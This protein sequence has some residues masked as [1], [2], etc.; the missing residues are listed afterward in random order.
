MGYDKSV[1]CTFVYRLPGPSL[2]VH[3]LGTAQTCLC[4]YVHKPPGCVIASSTTFERSRTG[5]QRSAGTCRASGGPRPQWKARRDPSDAQIR[6]YVLAVEPSAGMRAQRP[7]H[8][9][10]AIDA[11]AEA[12]PLDDDACDAAMAIITRSTTGATPPPACASCAGSRAA[13][14]SCSPSTPTCSPATG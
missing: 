13:Q 14:S 9:A 10:P 11:G 3:K 1:D 8:F 6:R 12:L 2:D 5:D 4:P 7:A